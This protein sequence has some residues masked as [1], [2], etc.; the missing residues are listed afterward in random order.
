M[1]EL[2]N[3]G[4]NELGLLTAALAIALVH[5][6][7]PDEQNVIGNFITG[8][9]CVI[10]VIAAQSQYLMSLQEKEKKD[11]DNTEDLRKQIQEIQRKVD[12]IM[13]QYP[14]PTSENKTI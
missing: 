4:A 10:L 6:K 13:S 5:D 8:I 2:E 9:G 11:G 14:K 3:I 1:S 12:A 7:T